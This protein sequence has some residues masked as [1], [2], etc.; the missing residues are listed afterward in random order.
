[1]KTDDREFKGVNRFGNRS[2]VVFGNL[3]DPELRPNG[4]ELV[5]YG[6]PVSCQKDVWKTIPTGF[7]FDIPLAG[8]SV[9]DAIANHLYK[10]RMAKTQRTKKGHSLCRKFWSVAYAMDENQ[11]HTF[12]LPWNEY[13]MIPLFIKR[14]IMS[15]LMKGGRNFPVT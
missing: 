2:H 5:G 8:S 9:I 6:T 15:M 11:T 13:K 4:G 14:R 12:I 10:K 7:R 1:M 3:H